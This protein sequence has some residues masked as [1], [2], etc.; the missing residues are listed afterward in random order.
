[1]KNTQEDLVN[2]KK[3]ILQE[4]VNFY[5]KLYFE[6]ETNNCELAYNLFFP[7]INEKEK[8]ECEKPKME[9]ECF[10]AL[11][12]L[13]NNKSSGMDGFSI[14]V[15]KTF[16]QDLKEIF[17]KCFSYS[18]VA[19]QLCGSQYEGLIT[20]IQKFGK[21]TMYISNYR[22][23]TFLNCDFEIISKVIN[24]RIC[25]LLSKLVNYSQNGFI[26]GRNIGDN[27]RLMFDIIDYANC[28]KVPRAGFSMDLCKAFNSFKWSFIFALF[29][30]YRFGCKIIN[31]INILYKKHI[32]SS[33]IWPPYT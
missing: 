25:G 33:E 10:K 16:W 20:P 2:D 31:W 29:K 13:S 9:S 4:L 26:R 23:I 21:N 28:K 24:N 17:L 32:H 5:E 19:N 18:L 22:P 12:E 11:S 15:Y 6:T 8:M 27:I 3:L 7:N 30:L 1:M 14:K